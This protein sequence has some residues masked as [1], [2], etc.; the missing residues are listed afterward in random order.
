MVALDS[1]RIMLKK[2]RI[3][4]APSILAD[5]SRLSGIERKKFFIKIQL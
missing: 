5:S 3:S 2:M 4:L 1:G